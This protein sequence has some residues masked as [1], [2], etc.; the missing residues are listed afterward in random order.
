MYEIVGF[1]NKLDFFVSSVLNAFTSICL[2][3]TSLWFGNFVIL[4]V[5][6]EITKFFVNLKNALHFLRHCSI[7]K[8]AILKTSS[9]YLC[10]IAFLMCPSLRL[11]HFFKMFNKLRNHQNTKNVFCHYDLW[12][13]FNNKTGRQTKSKVFLQIYGLF[14]IFANLGSNLTYVFSTISD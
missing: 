11:H 9:S 4:I 5:H 6:Q 2:C 3:I 13:F 14:S 1:N 12:N 7:I 8:N 10:P